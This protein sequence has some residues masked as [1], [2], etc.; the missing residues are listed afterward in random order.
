MSIFAET[1]KANSRNL[2][3]V[4]ALRCIDDLIVLNC[5]VEPLQGS[6]SAG[7]HHGPL[8]RL[9]RESPDRVERSPSGHHHELD[10]TGFILA[11]EGRSQE[12]VG[13]A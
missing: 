11:H 12:P 3:G 1:V 6:D 9:A 8:Q 4:S 2:P 5:L 13:G 7:F 10:V